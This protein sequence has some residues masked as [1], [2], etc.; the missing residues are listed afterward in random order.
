MFYKDV[1][2]KYLWCNT[3]FEKAIGVKREVI[4]GNTDYE[5]TTKQVADLFASLDNQVI[6]TKKANNYETTISH[7]DGL[8]YDTIVSRTPN[9]DE[10]NKVLGIK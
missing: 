6:N 4:V 9:L 10:I 1:Y 2:G 5:I 3:A 8:M 7:A